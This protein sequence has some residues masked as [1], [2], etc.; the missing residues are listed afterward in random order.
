VGSDKANVSSRARKV[1]PQRTAEFTRISLTGRRGATKMT[2]IREGIRSWNAQ[3]E[4]SAGMPE[5]VGTHPGKPAPWQNNSCGKKL[6][7][8]AE[9]IDLPRHEAIELL[10]DLPADSPH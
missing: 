7:D 2:Y 3:D 4:T 6:A 5:F 9:P 8:L 1:I 10:P